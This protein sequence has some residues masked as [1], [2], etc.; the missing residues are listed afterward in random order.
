MTAREPRTDAEW[1]EAVD[2]AFAC[3]VLDSARQYGFVE[4]GPAVN[5]ERCEEILARG[6]ERDVTPSADAI[7]RFIA[8][9]NRP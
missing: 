8:D 9:V 3:L 6:R 1:Q 2:G 4:G 5:V 7:E